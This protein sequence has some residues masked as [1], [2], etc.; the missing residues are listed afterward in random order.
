MHAHSVSLP[1]S[2]S[3]ALAEQVAQLKE[4]GFLILRAAVSADTATGLH[5]DLR[6]RFE[7]TPFCKG[8]F[9]GART[10]RF[11]GLLKRSRHAQDCVMHPT[12]LAIADQVL[13]PFCDRVQLN[14][15]QALQIH[16]G[17]VVQAPH[18]DQD[19]YW[20]PK[21]EMEYLFNVMWP[22]TP[23]TTANGATL[24]YRGSNRQQPDAPYDVQSAVAAEM[25]PGD[26]LVF[27]GS[28]LH[29]AGAN[30]TEVP[31]TGMIIGYSLG[32]LKPYENQWLAY[33]PEVA[34]RFSPELA[35]LVGY[36]ENAPNLGNYEGQCP[37]VLLRDS[38]PEYLEAIDYV[39]EQQQAGLS[40]FKGR[41]SLSDAA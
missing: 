8:D 9:Y 32:W 18:R 40:W 19:M 28:T 27:L 29:C 22:F 37:S 17:E 10:K 5:N 36:C 41:Q 34:K 12:I 23:Y 31:R 6:E 1:P 4:E 26:A 25:T 21:G 13:G 24:V 2:P 14:L 39:S 30:R 16:P 11:G 20:G 35:A 3:P 15:T 7:K 33:P 38:V